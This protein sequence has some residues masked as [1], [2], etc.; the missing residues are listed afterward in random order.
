MIKHVLNLAAKFTVF[1]AIMFLV[2]KFVPYEEFVNDFITRNISFENALKITELMLGE[3]DLEAYE[4]MREYMFILT[5]TL[6][7]V[8]L[9]GIL[10]TVMKAFT[11]KQKLSFHIREFTLSIIRRLTKIFSFT[12]LFWSLLHLSLNAII[13]INYPSNTL[14]VIIVILDLLISIAI[15]LTISYILKKRPVKSY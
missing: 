10:L 2:A 6:I 8:P 12:F 14:G 4:S 1:I 5:N 7:S 9:Y 15:Y 13:Y 11:N 3:P